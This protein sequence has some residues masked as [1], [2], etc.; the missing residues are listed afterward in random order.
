MLA[1]DGAGCPAWA[2]SGDGRTPLHAAAEQGW[3]SMLD[4][5]VRRLDSKVYSPSAE[6]SFELGCSASSGARSSRA[7]RLVNG[8][9][10]AVMYSWTKA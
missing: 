5:L 10:I 2:R 4:L 3:D 6:S 8:L 7:L 9:G 1:L